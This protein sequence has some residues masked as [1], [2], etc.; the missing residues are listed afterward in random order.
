[1]QATPATWQMLVD[2]GWKGSDRLTALCGGEALPAALAA[3]ILPHVASLWNLYGPT[4]TTIWSLAARVDNADAAIPIGR[5][6]ANTSCL[7]VD[8]ML[9]PVGPGIAGELLIGGAGLARGYH[10]DPSSTAARFIP[11]PLDPESGRKV[12]RTGDLVHAGSDGSLQ[13]L[14]RRDQQVKVRGFRIELGEVEATLRSHASVHDAAVLAVGE[15]LHSRRLAAFVERDLPWDGDG[16]AA[17]LRERLPHYMVPDVI[18]TVA[19]IPRLPNG[20]VDRRRLAAEAQLPAAHTPDTERPRTPVEARLVAVLEELL[21]HRRIG[22]DDNFFALGGTSLLGIRYVTRIND[23]YNLRLGVVALMRAP[24]IAAMAQLVVDQLKGGP[25]AEP[26]EL[27]PRLDVPVGQ[28]LWRPLAMMRAEGS[29]DEID[30]AAI[31][32][33]PDDLLD[34]AR[35][36]G[37]EEAVRRQMPRADDPQWGAVCRLSL[38]TIALVLVP[39]F[40]I[41][42]IA[43]PDAALQ[44]VQAAADYAARLGA[45]TAALTGLIPAVTDLGRAL[46]LPSGLAITTGHATTASAVVLTA[47]RAARAVERNLLDEAVAFVGLGA[48]GTAALRLMLDRTIHPRRLILCDVPARRAALARLADGIRTEFGYGGGIEI[49][50]APGVVPDEVYGSRFIIG[51]TNVPGVLEIER[52]APGTIVID[53]SFPHCFDVDKAIDRARSRGDVLPVEGGLVSPPEAIEWT[54]TLPANLA[55]V[56][57]LHHA[58]G[59]LPDSSAITGCILSSLL[60]QAHGAPATTGPVGVTACR[61]HWQALKRMDI[62]AAP[63]RC[64]RWKPSDAYLDHFRKLDHDGGW[65]NV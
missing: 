18:R 4:E 42:L 32:Y 31:A 58:A 65:R 38:G 1:M 49:A 13:F 12:F 24:S 59:L 30:A 63:L 50:A 43:D 37:A 29:F 61:D 47:T 7:V 36:I 22:L 64:G 10:N 23:I 16:L 45:G 40:G 19:V 6:I 28:K 11:D 25:T 35:R 8:E 33:L 48:V 21:E 39:R 5:P 60:S 54:A 44:A 34:A 17:H 52:L 41:D 2:A 53:D 57:G 3:K 15:D 56:L 62:G 55:A 14:G 51:A 20:K 9:R 27:D 26:R 46:A